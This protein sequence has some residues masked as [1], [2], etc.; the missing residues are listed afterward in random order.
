MYVSWFLTCLGAIAAGQ[1]ATPAAPGLIELRGSWSYTASQNV[2]AFEVLVPLPLAYRVQVPLTFELAAKPASAL[3]AATVREDRPGNW[4]AVLSVKALSAEKAV[5]LDWKSVVLVAPRSFDDLP[6]TA[7]LPEEWPPEALPWLASTRYV[8][9]DAPEIAAVAEEI[10]GERTDVLEILE[11]TL[12]RA[13]A[14]HRGQAGR[15]EDLGAVE[16]LARQGSCT[17]NA[18][19]L[20]ALFRA[21]G[22]PARILAGYPTW[23]GPLQTHYIVEAW[24]PRYGWYPIESTML[25]RGWEPYEQVQV[26]IVPPEYE[27]ERAARRFFAGSG[28]PYLSLTELPG[29]EGGVVH[30]GTLEAG[31]NRDHEA[32]SSKRFRGKGEAWVEAL[33]LAQDRWE[34]WLESSP[35]LSRGRLATRLSAHQLGEDLPDLTRRLRGR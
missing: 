21:N 25:L 9:A 16:A 26:A 2:P 15:C 5:Q 18:N 27:G 34:R 22:I 17:S 28:V 33:D 1:S 31:Q 32:R 14:I 7:P 24:V 35:T 10:R 12:E 8:Q 23:S 4:I 29:F 20:A 30:R 19:L 3:A 6:E 11:A 13:R